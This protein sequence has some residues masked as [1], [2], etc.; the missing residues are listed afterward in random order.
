MGVQQVPTKNDPKQTLVFRT[1]L[2]SDVAE[3]FG[4]RDLIYA[5]DVPRSGVAS[6]RL[7]GAEVNCE[8]HFRHDG[9]AFL[10]TAEVGK[11]VAKLEGDG[12]KLIFLVKFA[13][14]LDEVA[15][16]AKAAKIDPIEITFKPAQMALIDANGEPAQ[17]P[18][19][20]EETQ[21]L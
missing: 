19:E 8:I 21:E 17:A 3:A 14:L 20:T 13:G 9:A 5:G 4:C 15:A 7:D 2:T 11:Y 18:E 16:L 6:M 1:A 12:P 10:V